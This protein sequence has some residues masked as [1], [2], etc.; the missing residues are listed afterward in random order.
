MQGGAVCG[1][2][3]G[4]IRPAAGV[5]GQQGW[6][7]DLEAAPSFTP[8][9][10]L[11]AGKIN[12]ISQEHGGPLR[13]TDPRSPG[14][15][16]DYEPAVGLDS[17]PY[18]APRASLMRISRS[19]FP[20]AMKEEPELAP[21][22]VPGPRQERTPARVRQADIARAAGVSQAA[23]ST[24]WAAAWTGCADFGADPQTHHRRGAGSG[25]FDQSR[26]SQPGGRPQSASR[27][28]HVRGRLP[29]GGREFI[30]HSCSVSSGRQSASATTC[31]CLQARAC[32]ASG[33]AS[34]P[35]V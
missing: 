11:R 26:R 29:G 1:Q 35:A 22:S 18:M 19:V 9:C 14:N 2:A 32:P 13:I 3:D 5:A 30:N 23:V 12:R 24:A 31:C 7:Q 16:L 28:L 33:A 10:A 27:C 15:G 4:R 21:P 17:G 34:M 20:K 25:L 8:S 6:R